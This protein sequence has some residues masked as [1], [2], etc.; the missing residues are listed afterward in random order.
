MLP[1]NDYHQQLLTAFLNGLA[2]LEQAKTKTNP[3]LLQRIWQT[4]RG[5]N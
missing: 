1:I 3:N 5:K 4:I 2:K